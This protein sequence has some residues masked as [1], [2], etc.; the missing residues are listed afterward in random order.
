MLDVLVIGG[1]V[2]GCSIAR[3]LARYQ[4]DIMLLEKT[5]DIC[6]GQSKANTAIVHGGYDAT[7]GTLKA[8]YNVLGNQMMKAVCTELGVPYQNNQSLVVSFSKEGRPKLQE[9]LQQG[10]TNGV[11]GGL[12]LI[13]EDEL[14]RREPNIG[15][16]AYEALVVEAG[17]IVCPY[18]LTVGYAENA[19]QNGVQFRRNTEVTG[20]QKDDD[21]FTVFT[22]SG[23]FRTKAVVNAAGLYADNI[24]NMVS[25]KKYTIYPRRGEYYIVDKALAGKFNSAVFQL[26][27]KM[28]KGILI[29][30]TVDGTL[31]IGPTAEDIDDKD[32]TRSTREG[33]DKALRV[34]SLTWENIP[35]RSFITTFSGIRAHCDCNDFV[36]GE[37]PDVSCFFNALGIESPGLTSAP[38]IACH[39][40]QDIAQKLNADKK[41]FFN[42]IRKPIPKFREMTNAERAAAICSNP[43][44]AKIICRCETITEAEIREAIRRPVGART[45]DGIKRRTRAGMGRCQAGFCTSLVVDILC[46]ELGISPMEASKFGG[47]SYL[48]DHALFEKEG[49]RCD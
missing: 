46:E 2:I 15:K 3:E 18:E 20:L 28:G 34:G 4:L 48:L 41:P 10:V 14:R 35:N 25:E 13:E 38:A 22:N 27:T 36:I 32:D 37:A 6:N 11:S 39:L 43:D 26:P 30:P 23:L 33:L 19:A 5:A 45:L 47:N 42:P 29:A 12:Y 8:K 24:N 49:A 16:D 44:Y 21:G 9:L 7:P 40:A 17:G 31:L 1:G